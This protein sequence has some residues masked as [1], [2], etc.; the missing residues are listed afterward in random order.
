MITTSPISLSLSYRAENKRFST[1]KRTKTG[2][3]QPKLNAACFVQSCLTDADFVLFSN[4]CLIGTRLCGCFFNFLQK[5]GYFTHFSPL[6][7]RIFF[8]KLFNLRRA[9][10]GGGAAARNIGAGFYSLAQSLI[11]PRHPLKRRSQLFIFPFKLFKR[12]FS[13]QS[14]TPLI[15]KKSFF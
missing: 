2:G 15:L 3:I 7:T 8:Q 13:A 6:Q 12:F 9:L 5:V 11:R 10:R 4:Y 1:L 14:F